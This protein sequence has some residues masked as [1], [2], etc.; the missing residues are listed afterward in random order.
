VRQ[1]YRFDSEHYYKEP[2]ILQDDEAI[3]SDCVYDAPQDG[4]YKAKR[5]NG[6]WVEALTDEEINA[7]RTPSPKSEV[8]I[9]RE[10]VEELRKEIDTL[11]G[12]I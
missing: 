5:M 2:V 11:K 1:V 6:Q 9:L 3:P 7:L 10:Q 4:M 12:V 8:E